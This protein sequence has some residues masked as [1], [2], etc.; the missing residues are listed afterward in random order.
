MDLRDGCHDLR[1]KRKSTDS[2]TLIQI[3]MELDSVALLSFH[4]PPYCSIQNINH[5]NFDIERLLF[6]VKTQCYQ[7]I[8]KVQC[9]LKKN[10]EHVLEYLWE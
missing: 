9:F 2:Q 7:E 4:P 5:V 3:L 6:L 10:E 8:L 1:D